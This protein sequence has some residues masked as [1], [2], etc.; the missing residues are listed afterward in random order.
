LDKVEEQDLFLSLLNM[1]EKLAQALM[2]PSLA[3]TSPVQLIAR[4]V[5]GAVGA[6]AQRLV[7]LDKARGED[8][9]RHNL[10][11]EEYLARF[12]RA[13]RRA[14][15]SPAPSTVRLVLGPPGPAAPS[16][17]TGDQRLDKVEEEEQLQLLRNMEERPVQLLV[18][19]EVATTCLV[20]LIAR[21]VI[22]VVGVRVRGLATLVKVD[23][24]GTFLSATS[25]VGYLVRF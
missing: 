4:L 19:L 18:M 23:E 22:G 15:N 14:T 11:T 3:M 25:M 17:A 7:A 1:E 9:W 24:R 10:N 8:L 13:Q 5:L 20:Q 16:L 2:L 12:S 6:P 21:W